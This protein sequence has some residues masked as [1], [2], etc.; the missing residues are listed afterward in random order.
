MKTR[1]KYLG[2]ITPSDIKTEP[3]S[4]DCPICCKE[5]CREKLTHSFISS[6]GEY[7]TFFYRTH[8]DCW[9]GLTEK[10]RKEYDESFVD[11]L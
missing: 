8:K 3:I 6:N 10:E 4:V 1:S 9:K 5:L 7:V 11:N 2:I